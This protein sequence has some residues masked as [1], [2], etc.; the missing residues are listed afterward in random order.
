MSKQ[1]QVAAAAKA[2]FGNRGRDWNVMERLTAESQANRALTIG[3]IVLCKWLEKEITSAE[4]ADAFIDY[5]SG[6]AAGLRAVSEA[7]KNGEV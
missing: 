4:N 7:I 5:A 6:Y 1:D 3:D 2:V